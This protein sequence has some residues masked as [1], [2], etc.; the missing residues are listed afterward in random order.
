M[1][2]RCF[3]NQKCKNEFISKQLLQFSAMIL[4]LHFNQ[5]LN[6]LVIYLLKYD[7]R[8]T[9]ALLGR[10][11]RHGVWTSLADAN[12]YIACQMTA[13]WNI[14]VRACQAEYMEKY[15]LYGIVRLRVG[16]CVNKPRTPPGQ[17]VITR[18]P[19]Q[20]FVFTS[21]TNLLPLD[22]QMLAALL[23]MVA[24]THYLF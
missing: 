6:N 18:S 5:Y 11:Q 14:R 17:S 21:C 10:W 9:R 13:V 3:M 16:C 22:I 19:M 15:V 8:R 7:E 4:W 2:P 24:T 1:T 12:A 23:V 20:I